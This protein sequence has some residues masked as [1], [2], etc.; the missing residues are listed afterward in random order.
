MNACQLWTPLRARA[1][2]PYLIGAGR[3]QGSS[4]GRLGTGRADSGAGATWV[5][6][7]AHA[8]GQCFRPVPRRASGSRRAWRRR[9]DRSR[10]RGGC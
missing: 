6:T 4:D 3:G 8:A 5:D 1:A 10:N 7:G 9:R 2:P